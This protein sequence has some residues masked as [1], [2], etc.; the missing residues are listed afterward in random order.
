MPP[1]NLPSYPIKI[2]EKNGKRSVFDIIRRKYVALTPEEWVRQHF[3]RYLIEEKDFPKEL[4]ANEVFLS[5]N[6]MA[7]RCDTV[8]YNR[9]LDPLVIIEYKAPHIS[10]TQA[11]FDQITRY[12]M[13]M[14]V[15]YLIISNG[16]NHYCCKI[17]YQK[18]RYT[19]LEEIPGYGHITQ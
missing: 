3:T 14:R 17:D 15:N 16:I 7:R 2:V 8:I 12:N 1:L 4:M 5:L 6:G 18:Q 11:V 9:F 19:F 10:I 13:V